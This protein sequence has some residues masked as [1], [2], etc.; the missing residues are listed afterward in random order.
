MVEYLQ[1]CEGWSA[2][3]CGARRIAAGF[4]GSEFLLWD[5][6]HQCEVRV[7]PMIRVVSFIEDEQLGLITF[8][9]ILGPSYT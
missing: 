6:T 9:S 4:T 8:S 3:N 1:Y 7:L 5:L 2:P